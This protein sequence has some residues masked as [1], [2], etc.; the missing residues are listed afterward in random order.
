MYHN[1][2]HNPTRNTLSSKNSILIHGN[3]CKRKN[4]YSCEHGTQKSASINNCA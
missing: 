3:E 4:V 1:K 2:V